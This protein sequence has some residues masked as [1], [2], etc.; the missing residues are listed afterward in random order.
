MDRQSLYGAARIGDLVVKLNLRPTP[1]WAVVLL[2][3]IALSLG[4]C[5]RKGALDLPPSASGGPALSATSP[6]AEAEAANKPNLFNANPADDSG[7]AA[8]KGRKR[9]F[10]L[11]PMLGDDYKGTR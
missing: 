2:S 9:S 5:G 6:D 10:V 3:V 8:S 7:P 1:G 11:D 4:G